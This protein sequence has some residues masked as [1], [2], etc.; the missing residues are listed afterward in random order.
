MNSSNLSY[1]WICP[2][3]GKV[4]SPY[5]KECGCKDNNIY[6]HSNVN[7]TSFNNG[8]RCVIPDNLRVCGNSPTATT[9]AGCC[10]WVKT[11]L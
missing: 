5:T 10:N 6:K 9:C 7:D 4:L 11:S 2:R 1:G 8:Y 3:C